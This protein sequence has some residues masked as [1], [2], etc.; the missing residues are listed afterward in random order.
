MAYNKDDLKQVMD[1]NLD[2]FSKKSAP[3]PGHDD[4][5]DTTPP[6]AAAVQPA[7]APAV[8]KKSTAIPDDVLPDA[9]KT[10]APIVKPAAAEDKTQDQ[11]QDLD[12]NDPVPAGMTGKIAEA[13]KDARRKKND[14]IRALQAKLAEAEKNGS[15]AALSELQQRI[16]EKDELIAKADFE[17]SDA[18]KKPYVLPI[19]ERIEFL[20]KTFVRLGKD[21]AVLE[22]ALSLPVD[23]RTQFVTDEFKDVAPTINTMLMTVDELVERKN[24]ALAKHSTMQPQLMAQHAEEQRREIEAI[25]STAYEE[26]KAKLMEKKEHFL[27]RRSSTDQAWNQEVEAMQQHAAEIIMKG[28]IHEQTVAMM[29]G[30]MYDKLL[31]QSFLMGARIKELEQSVLDISGVSARITRTPAPTSGERTQPEQFDDAAD[32]T[33]RFMQRRT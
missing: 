21:A 10:K 6:A 4:D 17:R 12:D 7:P 33:R 15:T 29:K 18:F 25:K 19:I 30:A 31:E 8:V 20:K 28:D 32:V 11:K 1:K 27:L 22:K 9:L 26:A 23:K 2:A 13:F 14:E 16:I 3:A 5:T 24:E